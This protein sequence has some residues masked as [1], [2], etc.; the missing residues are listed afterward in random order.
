MHLLGNMLYLWT[1][2]DNVEDAL[3]HFKF[4]IFYL[5]CGVLASIA[6]VLSGPNSIIPS[7]GAS[8]AIA[9]VLGGYLLMFPVRRVRVLVGWFGIIE[10]PAIIVIGLWIGIQIFSGIGS[11]A[12]TDASKGGVA[13]WAHIGGALAGLLLVS[14]FRNHDT[15]QRVD[16][17]MNP[18]AGNWGGGR[19]YRY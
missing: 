2:G 18:S 12:V 13:Y 5:V 19:R 10:L 4:L 1:F 8:G 3:G 6:H 11:I 7:L 16:A 15:Q 14:F 17:R 9:G